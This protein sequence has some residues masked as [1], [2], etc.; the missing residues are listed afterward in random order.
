MFASIRY[1]ALEK[2]LSLLSFTS[3]WPGTGR[4]GG[5]G[6]SANDIMFNGALQDVSSWVL[7]EFRLT[8]VGVC[9]SYIIIDFDKIS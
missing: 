9:V 4:A 2:S 7:L 8:L 5:C 3:V 1:P 6:G